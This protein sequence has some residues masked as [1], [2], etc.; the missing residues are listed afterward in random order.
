MNL[1]PQF[2]AIRSR[3]HLDICYQHVHRQIGSQHGQS[4]L[5]V[6]SLDDME[7]CIRQKFGHK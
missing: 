2:V 7:L 4:F 3:W 6:G 1:T 5:S